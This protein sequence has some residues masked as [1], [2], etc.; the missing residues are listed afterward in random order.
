M[1]N[2][3]ILEKRARL[4]NEALSIATMEGRKASNRKLVGKHYKFRNCYSCP[5][6]ESDYWW[7]YTKV[8]GVEDGAVILWNF[9]TDKY[10]EISIKFRDI[11]TT[12]HHGYVEI[13]QDEF[14][15]EW[16]KLKKLIA[17][18]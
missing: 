9:Q 5:D 8:I 10:G 7:S 17:G 14:R 4:A 6:K 16:A 1:P 3:K 18:H 13:T 12:I 11:H 2:I 15:A